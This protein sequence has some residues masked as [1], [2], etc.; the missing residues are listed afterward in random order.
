VLDTVRENDNSMLQKD[1]VDESE[2]SKAKISSVISE[3][4][5]KGIV[6]KSKEGRSNKISIS[7]KY[8]Y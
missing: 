3:L 6:K 7:R 8:R 4:E 5:E 1:I 2:Y